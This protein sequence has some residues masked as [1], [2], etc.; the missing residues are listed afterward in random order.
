MIWSLEFDICALVVCLLFIIYSYNERNLPI[1]R[2]LIFL[3]LLFI[4]FFLTLF[5][6]LGSVIASYYQIFPISL[7]YAVNIVYYITLAFSPMVFCVYCYHLI[8]EDRINYKV[9]TILNVPAITLSLIALFSPINHYIFRINELGMFEYGPGR[10]SMYY[11]AVF[12]M[13]ISV[14]FIIYN[15]K[16]V[17]TKR[18]FY[19]LS[20]YIAITIITF[21]I[22]FWFIG[23]MQTVP[24]GIVCGITT[25]FLAFQ[26]PF[27][28]RDSYTN[29]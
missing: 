4:Q 6:I 21:T 19:S 17:L 12:Y 16:K 14:G 27:Y 22:Q 28:Y 10:I 15:P 8:T 20:F 13:I 24:F 7:I 23:Y 11:E 3:C 2:N 18:Y 1:R 9:L 25:I 5:D 29:L 26:S